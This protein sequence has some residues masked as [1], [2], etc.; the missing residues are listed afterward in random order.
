MTQLLDAT[1]RRVHPT[2]AELLHRVLTPYRAKRCEY[3]T[4]AEVTHEGDPHEGGQLVASCSFEIPESCYIDDTGHFNSV[5]FNICFNQ[6]A[7]YLMAKSVKE[8][9]IE[10]FSRWTLEQFW[11]RQLADVFIT[12]F[13]S[14]FRSAMRGR[15]F[16]GEIRV[17]DIAEWDGNDLRDPLVMLRTEARYWDEHGGESHGEIAAAITNPPAN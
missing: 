1:G 9:L 15:R 12:D 11:D 7:Y 10:P 17:V 4:E 14:T 16:K 13:R 6:M 8:S 5:E 2:D 3:L